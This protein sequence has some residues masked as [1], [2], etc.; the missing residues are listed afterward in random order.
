MENKFVTFSEEVSWPLSVKHEAD[1]EAVVGE[2]INEKE[3]EDE[4]TED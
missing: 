3:D 2:I 1:G 4:S